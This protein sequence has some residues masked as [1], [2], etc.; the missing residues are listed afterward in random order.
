MRKRFIVLLIAIVIFALSVVFSGHGEKV[1]EKPLPVLEVSV[2]EQEIP[3]DITDHPVL[4][5]GL[6][7]IG[8]VSVL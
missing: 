4:G 7:N 8:K 1:A 2:A 3:Y 5:N 6:L